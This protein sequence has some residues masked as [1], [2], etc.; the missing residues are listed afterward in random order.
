M[1]LD[2]GYADEFRNFLLAPEDFERLQIKIVLIPEPDATFVAE[3]DSGQSYNYA[4]EKL[5]LNRHDIDAQGWLGMRTRP[6]TW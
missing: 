2:P 6:E 3:D 4:A 1:R 5:H